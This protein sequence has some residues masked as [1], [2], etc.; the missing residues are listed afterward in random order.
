MH[1]WMKIICLTAILSF[2]LVALAGQNT[3]NKTVLDGVYTADQAAK[4]EAEFQDKCTKCHEADDA[5]G[6]L[7]VGRTFIDRWRED[8]LDVLFDFMSTRMPA[9]DT[10]SLSD[11]AYLS[12]LS[13]LLEANGYPQGGKA[14]T[15][16]MLPR[17]RLVGKDGPKPLP[18]NTLVQVVGCLTQAAD[19]SWTVTNVGDPARVRRETEME[20]TPEQLKKA[21]AKPLG[22][23]T[24]G[25]L[26]FTRISFDF[27]PESYRGHKVYIH[28]VLLRQPNANAN[29][30]IS[31][32]S[33]A[34]VS[35]SCAQ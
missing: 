26:N 25:L 7:L 8:N 20:P 15:V 5:G 28:G 6:P 23:L 18:N 1:F 4:G 17:I 16:D 33:L 14:L 11:S 30:R 13:Y 9:D 22:K 10:S 24:F 21:E 35:P 12:I 19:S 34:S 2:G 3:D 27:K 29:D 31:I 32:T